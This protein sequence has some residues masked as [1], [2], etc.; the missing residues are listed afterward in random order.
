MTDAPK[1]P[2]DDVEFRRVLISIGIDPD[3][4]FSDLAPEDLSA[5]PQDQWEDCTHLVPPA[6]ILRYLES[7]DTLTHHT[8]DMMELA[9]EKAYQVSSPWY[10]SSTRDGS[11]DAGTLQVRHF[12]LMRDP[13]E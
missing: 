3:E 5:I 2:P 1:I 4:D 13:S 11:E 7:G 12:A 10:I 9:M 8:I 6:P